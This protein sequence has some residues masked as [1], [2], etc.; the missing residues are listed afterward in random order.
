MCWV[1]GM[2]D[3]PNIILSQRKMFYFCCSSFAIELY[4]SHVCISEWEI[5]YAC[6]C[7]LS[8]FCSF[9]LS[10]IFDFAFAFISVI[11][12][13]FWIFGRA[14]FSGGFCF[15][16]ANLLLIP[17]IVSFSFVLSVS[18][19]LHF[20]QNDAMNIAFGLVFYAHQTV[21]A[22]QCSFF[23]GEFYV[24]FFLGTLYGCFAV[25][26]LYRNDS[27][28]AF[29]PCELDCSMHSSTSHFECYGWIRQNRFSCI[30]E[31]RHHFG[32]IPNFVHTTNMHF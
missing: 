27:F 14:I 2:T 30:K 25:L 11:F 15:T 29:I 16:H 4:Y 17:F 20:F 9:F 6:V 5:A 7:V 31:Q 18:L 3:R 26:C 19:P 12:I 10:A 23:N 1:Y 24:H 13:S 22:A 28:F 21:T 32:F 8:R